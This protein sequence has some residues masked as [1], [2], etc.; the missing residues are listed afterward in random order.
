[1]VMQKT[2]CLILLLKNFQKK[3]IYFELMS[4]PKKIEQKLKEGS[5]KARKIASSCPPELKI[6]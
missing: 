6:N 1:M 2:N 4:E 3:E 5:E